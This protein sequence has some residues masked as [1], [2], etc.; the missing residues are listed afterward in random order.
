[1]N[2]KK[3]HILNNNKNKIHMNNTTNKTNVN[4]IFFININFSFLFSHYCLN[5]MFLQSTHQFCSADLKKDIS[6]KYV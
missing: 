2:F 6:L 1:M 5:F 3:I 4:I